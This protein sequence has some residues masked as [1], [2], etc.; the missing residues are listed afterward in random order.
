MTQRGSAV[1]FDRMF[2]ESDDPWG[3][4]D[5][6]Y[7]ARKRALT[8]AILPRRRY[9]RAFEPGCANGETSV[10][11]AA[12]CDALLAVD[13]CPRAVELARQRLRGHAGVRV[14]Q[15]EVPAAWPGGEFDLIVISELAYYL[16]P[17]ACA[18]LVDAA[19]GSLAPGG[20]LVCCHWRPPIEGC[21]LDGDAVHALIE[22]CMG[23]APLAA[24]RDA[25]FR[26]AVWSADATSVATREGLR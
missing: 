11:L 7:E 12:R 9:R 8:L 4:R 6:W 17:S 16:D 24:Y 1:D 3:F 22:R 14:E 10:A 5:R 18:R 23:E 25:D 20:Q 26:L 21:A 15:M 2:A 19:A 13:G